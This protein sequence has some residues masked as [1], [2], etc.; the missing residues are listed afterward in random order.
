MLDQHAELLVAH[1][2]EHD[3]FRAELIVNLLENGRL[4][5]LLLPDEALDQ[6]GYVRDLLTLVVVNAYQQFHQVVAHVLRILVLASGFDLLE[7]VLHVLPLEVDLDGIS[8]VQLINR[9][10]DRHPDR[11]SDLLI[12]LSEVVL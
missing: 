5:M 11:V 1:L 6:F 12:V 7:G 9:L 8:L 4:L 10:Q 2:L 3:A